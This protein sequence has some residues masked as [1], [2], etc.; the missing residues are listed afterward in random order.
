MEEIWRKTIPI[1]EGSSSSGATQEAIAPAANDYETRETLSPRELCLNLGV[2]GF[3]WS[4]GIWVPGA[5]HGSTLW[6]PQREAGVHH[7]KHYLYK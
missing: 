5:W 7:E 6:I 3:D 4:S 1:F 2:R